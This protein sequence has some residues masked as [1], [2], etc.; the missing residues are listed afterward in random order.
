MITSR[1]FVLACL[2]AAGCMNAQAA[3]PSASRPASFDMS[4]QQMKEIAGAYRLSDGRTMWIRLVDDKLYV[5]L[6]R[7]KR[8]TL[9]A[10]DQ[11]TFTS[12]DRSISLVFDRGGSGQG[13][14]RVA[15]HRDDPLL[16]FS[17]L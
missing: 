12:T 15:Q 1:S 7:D 14:V 17:S 9:A 11:Y 3:P 5:D 16:R 13:E 8:Q 10:R 4:E 6:G 2:L